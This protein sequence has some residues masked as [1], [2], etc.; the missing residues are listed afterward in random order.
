METVFVGL[1]EGDLDVKSGFS[2]L[3]YFRTFSWVP[4]GDFGPWRLTIVEVDTITNNSKVV[5]PNDRL[6][7][8][9]ARLEAEWDVP[10]HAM[11]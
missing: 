2:V 3:W 8:G 10:K 6:I 5:E 11:Y 7:A 9:L 4:V 1:Y